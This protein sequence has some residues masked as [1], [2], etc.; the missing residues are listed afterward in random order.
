MITNLRIIKHF[1]NEGGTYGIY[2]CDLNGKKSVFV[3]ND[4]SVGIVTFYVDKCVKDCLPL[5][6]KDVADELIKAVDELL[7]KEGYANG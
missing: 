4:K 1:T 3:R 5:V 2:E 6:R 7:Q